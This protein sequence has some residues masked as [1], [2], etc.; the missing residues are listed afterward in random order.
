[1]I[2]A[3][4]I[5]I[6]IIFSTLTNGLF[7][8][9]I[10]SKVFNIKNDLSFS[11]TLLLGLSFNTAI[12]GYLSLFIKTGMITNLILLLSGL[13]YLFIDKNN[14]VI[15]AEYLTSIKKTHWTVW[16]LGIGLFYLVLNQTSSIT[17][18]ADTPTYHALAIRFIEDFAVIP[19]LGNFYHRLAFNNSW[20]TTGALYG[21]SF[22]GIQSFNVLGHFMMIFSGFFILGGLNNLIN[23]SRKISDW[24]RIVLMPV[25]LYSW[26]FPH[27]GW[28]STPSPDVPASLLVWLVFIYLFEIIEDNKRL[29]FRSKEI[30]LIIIGFFLITVKLSV[31]PIALPLLFIAFKQL[32]SKPKN[33]ALSALIALFIIT[34]WMARNYYLSG[35]IV[36]PYPSIDLF[37]AEWEI[38]N[39]IAEAEKTEIQNWAKWPAWFKKPEG[40]NFDDLS[41]SEWYKVWMENQTLPY[42]KLLF[43]ATFFLW[44]FYLLSSI[45]GFVR[46]K[47][48]IESK[49]D[50]FVI[51]ISMIIGWLYWWFSAPDLR[52][53]W[54]FIFINLSLFLIYFLKQLFSLVIKNEIKHTPVLGMSIG[55]MAMLLIGF[56]Y[57]QHYELVSKRYAFFNEEFTSEKIYL[58]ADYPLSY[59][60]KLENV[61]GMDVYYEANI[62]YPPLPGVN[63][64]GNPKRSE[65]IGTTIQEGFKHKKK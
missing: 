17:L 4:G 29:E 39:E 44:G 45:W 43:Y 2:A 23:G 36:H 21:L 18:N 5:W 46:N 51:M 3:T 15:L 61:N 53:G 26:Y 11:I 33:L 28:T 22:L 6:Y 42:L 24:S 35:Y 13:T 25:F 55:I 8:R 37:N 19:G 49:L 64:I 27:I 60:L 12:A 32:K 63:L 54:G 40:K 58:P 30:S 50:E 9:G 38:P 14:K 57:Y 41:Y 34:P 48:N 10:I 56:N 59:S 1:M 31:A 20:F 65:P 62:H 52:F 16:L 7:V 47:D